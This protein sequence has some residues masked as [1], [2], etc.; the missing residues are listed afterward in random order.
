MRSHLGNPVHRIIREIAYTK[1]EIKSQQIV[2]E[3]AR[4]QREELNSTI[5]TARA[6]IR[7]AEAQCTK[8]QEKLS[9]KIDLSADDIRP[10]RNWPKLPTT[11]YGKVLKEL[12]RYLQ[13]AEEPLSSGDIVTHLALLF[14]MPYDTHD[15]RDETSNS[16]RKRLRR[17]VREGVVVRY[18]EEMVRDGK[19]PA[20]WLWIGPR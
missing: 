2:V 11:R 16:I 15:Q 6:V 10:I 4:K 7:K 8:L 13:D 17:L 19:T 12:V 18:P 14:G 1:G 20:L 3:K 9:H 5:K